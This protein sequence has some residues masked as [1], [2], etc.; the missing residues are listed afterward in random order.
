MLFLIKVYFYVRKNLKIVK[1]I[2]FYAVG[3]FILKYLLII[4][5]LHITLILKT[6]Y[7]LEPKPLPF[8][9]NSKYKHGGE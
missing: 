9:I 4:L 6:R 3:N 2:F 8:V 5:I 1:K 7:F